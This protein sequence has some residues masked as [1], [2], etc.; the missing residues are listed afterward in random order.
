MVQVREGI[1]GQKVNFSQKIV[2]VV[3]PKNVIETT[4]IFAILPVGP[5]SSS[6]LLFY[7]CVHVTSMEDTTKIQLVIL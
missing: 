6:S 3:V 5:A 4:I 7:L 1:S 2:I